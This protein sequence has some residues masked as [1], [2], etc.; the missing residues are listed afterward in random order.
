MAATILERESDRISSGLIVVPSG[1]VV[2]PGRPT[3]KGVDVI[4]AGHPVPDEGSQKAGIRALEIAASAPSD[5]SL[6]VL[7]SGGASALLAAP[8]EG[9][10]L[11]DKQ[12]VTRLLLQAGADIHAL[13][14]VRKHLSR[15]K[16][17]LLAAACPGAVQTLAISDVVGDDPSAIASGPTVADPTSFHD[18]LSAVGRHGVRDQVPASVLRHLEA[19]ARGERPETPKPNDP[20]LARSTFRLVG[21]ARDAVDGAKTAAESLGYAVA[22]RT[23][24]VVGEAR[25]AARSQ[26]NDAAGR[27]RGMPRPACILSSGETT[28]TVK[29]SGRGGRNQEFALACVQLIGSLGVAAVVASIGTDGVDGPTDA[30]GA[31]AD[32]ASLDRAGHAG[33]GTPA[34]FL[35]HN[36][37]FTFFSAMGDLVRTGPTGTN[38][39]D[40]Q[41][42]LV[43]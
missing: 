21:R 30:A 6:V 27:L 11:K 41:I 7:I 17:G 20:R 4:E 1:T 29:G 26:I 34:S 12:S 24:P 3:P 33:L 28:V 15:V 13:N 25:E 16:G 22:I 36:D 31:I 32:T 2:T 38:V 19:G 39:G 5:G 9:L 43:A 10:T 35:D 40:I 23:E 37:A 8:A 18:A 42:V 14:T